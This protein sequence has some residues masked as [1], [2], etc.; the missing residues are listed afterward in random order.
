M[1]KRE[2][3]IENRVATYVKERRGKCIKLSPRGLR[4]IPDRLILLP[5]AR[6]FFVELKRPGQKPRNNQL[7]WIR[8]LSDLGFCAFWSDSYEDT[9]KRIENA[10]SS[11]SESA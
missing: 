3:D 1:I 11:S 5:G 7:R 8:V 9:I 4:G 6:V 2:V 10:S